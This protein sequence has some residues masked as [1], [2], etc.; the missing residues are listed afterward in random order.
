MGQVYSLAVKRVERPVASSA[1]RIS[2]RGFFRRMTAATT[3]TRTTRVMRRRQTRFACRCSALDDASD[4][5]FQ[6]LAG[7]QLARLQ[8]SVGHFDERIGN[9]WRP[10]LSPTPGIWPP[11]WSESIGDK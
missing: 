8:D 1:I 4:L 10:I 2:R 9:P 7:A 6:A 3:P 5:V 11:F